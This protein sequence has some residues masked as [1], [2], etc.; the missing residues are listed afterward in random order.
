MTGL[1]KARETASRLKEE[2][3]KEQEKE[4]KT[5]AIVK[6]Q[7]EVIAH[8]REVAR[9]YSDNAKVGAD[10]LAGELPLLKVH[11]TGRSNKNFLA[12]GTEPNDGWF[13]YKQTAEQFQNVNVHVL[14][15]S[16][17]FRAEGLEGQDDV[18]NQIL[19]GAVIEN[20]EQGAFKP[21]IMY[22]TGLKLSYLWDFGKEAAKYT[23]SKPVPIPMFALTIRLK[24]RKIDNKYGR[25]WIVEFEILKN[26][27]GTPKLITDPQVF[28]YL[29]ESA[30]K[31]EDTIASLV[32]AKE[33][34]ENEEET[35][36]R[37]ETDAPAKDLPF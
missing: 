31:V 32:A 33:N 13:F 35:P 3:E 26:E 15:I 10:N 1:D 30:I 4:E 20:E 6:N 28:N 7:L 29:K 19:G 36:V 22:F 23:R 12:D 8:D 14:T 27:D 25:S 9:M 37:A 18:F 5:G 17:G 11:S 16:R 34:K 24:T 21:F 2:T